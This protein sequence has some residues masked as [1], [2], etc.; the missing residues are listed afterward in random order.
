[1]D[2]RCNI[3]RK[4]HQL[5]RTPNHC[6]SPESWQLGMDAWMGRWA[7]W[8][9]HRPETK[10]NASRRTSIDRTWRAGVWDQGFYAQKRIWNA[11]WQS[12]DLRQLNSIAL[13]RTWIGLMVS[14]AIYT[15]FA[16][17]CLQGGVRP[18]LPLPLEK[19]WTPLKSSTELIQGRLQTT[20]TRPLHWA[21]MS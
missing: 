2:Y 20:L 18:S 21:S 17:W 12:G 6:R 9:K 15:G 8:L 1:M 14:R 5:I 10:A 19:P 16:L 11:I 3:H 4:N 13:R 7:F